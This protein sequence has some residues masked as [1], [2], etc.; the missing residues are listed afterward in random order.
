MP[1]FAPSLCR[2]SDGRCR[3]SRRLAPLIDPPGLIRQSLGPGGRSH[4]VP[5]GPRE[6]EV[7]N[8]GR[9][10]SAPVFRLSTPELCIW[11]GVRLVH[12]M[13]RNDRECASSP[14]GARDPGGGLEVPAAAPAPPS[15]SSRIPRAPFCRERGEN[16][17]ECGTA[18]GPRGGVRKRVGENDFARQP[19]VIGALSDGT[20]CGDVFA[21]PR[22]DRAQST[23]P[24]YSNPLYSGSTE[25][26]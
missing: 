11:L 10:K 19:G 26:C 17:T 13:V 20:V 9:L 8:Q 5:C 24:A 16:C 22:R 23:C 14:W 21:G 7:V 1:P 15:S 12:G 18:A 4:R 2:P 6:D 3:P 25:T